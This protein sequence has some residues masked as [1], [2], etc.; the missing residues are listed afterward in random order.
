MMNIPSNRYLAVDSIVCRARYPQIGGNFSF[1]GI[2]CIKGECAHCGEHLLEDLIKSTNEDLLNENRRITW[3]KWLVKEGK[4]APEKCQ[5]KGTV[6][7]AVAELLRLLNPLKAHI[8]WSNWHRNTF[9]YIRHNLVRGQ[10]VQIFDF[11][12]NFRNIY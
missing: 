9:D 6:R 7:Q 1:P 12:M 5:L 8:F 2:S 3:R 4:S 11:A 10:V